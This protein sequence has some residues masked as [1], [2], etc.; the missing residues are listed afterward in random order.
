MDDRAQTEDRIHRPGQT[1]QKCTYIDFLARG[2]LDERVYTVLQEK[3]DLLDYM[4][5]KT[6]GEFLG[7]GRK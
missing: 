4:R 7:G 1:A 3:K 5:G 2:T 6:A